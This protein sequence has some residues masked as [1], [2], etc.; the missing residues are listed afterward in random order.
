MATGT[1]EAIA[2]VPGYARGLALH[3][4]PRLRRALEDP[5][6]GHLRRRTNRGLPRPAQV[7]RRCCRAEYRQH[8]GNASSST[9][10]WRRSSTC[11]RVP[12]VRC[13]TFGGSDSDG[14][15]VWLLPGPPNLATSATGKGAWRGRLVSELDVGGGRQGAAAR[16]PHGPATRRPS[17][18]RRRASQA[19]SPFADAGELLLTTL[20]VTLAPPPVGTR[21]DTKRSGPRDPVLDAAD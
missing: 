3:H 8:G 2:A 6:D 15:E 18:R 16:R 7:R 21:P 5:R 19:H 20:I 12:G 10:E 13:P 11:R 17:C 14:D 9:T 4:D 1:R